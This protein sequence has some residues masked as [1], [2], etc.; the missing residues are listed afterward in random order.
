MQNMNSD[1]LK[2]FRTHM[3]LF[4]QG[5]DSVVVFGLVWFVVNEK[6]G[7]QVFL[8]HYEV[9]MDVANQNS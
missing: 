3:H 1:V 2:Q 7:K 9:I 5:R 8:N 6:Q 4:Q